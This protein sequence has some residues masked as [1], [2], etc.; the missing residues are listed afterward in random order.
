MSDLLTVIKADGSTGAPS[1]RDKH[2][3]VQTQALLAHDERFQ[4]LKTPTLSRAEVNA[5][6]QETEQGYLYLRFD[7]PGAVPQEFWGHWGTHD[8]VAFKSGKVT[9]STTP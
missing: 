4:A 1:E 8:K 6:Q 3:L 5:I 2:L 7:V 9:V